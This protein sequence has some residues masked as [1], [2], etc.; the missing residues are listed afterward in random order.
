MSPNRKAEAA[1]TAT[2]DKIC[3][4]TAPI[5][6]DG[7][8][9]RRRSDKVLAHIIKPAAG[10]CG[11]TAVRADEISRPGTITSQIIQHLLN[12]EPVG[13]GLDGH[14]RDRGWAAVVRWLG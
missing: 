3:F 2:D 1:S 12:A 9:T 14:E 5:G 7:S 4:V 13:R 8:E 6:E 11:N 10:H